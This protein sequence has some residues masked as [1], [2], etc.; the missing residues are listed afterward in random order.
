MMGT[1]TAITGIIL[2]GG[3]NRRVHSENKAFFELG[4]RSLIGRIYDVMAA[5]FSRITIVTNRPLDYIKWDAVITTD[6]F[7]K[8]SSLT[9]IHA[10][11]FCLQTPY[12]FVCACDTPFLKKALVETVLAGVEDG[13]DVVVPE[14]AKGLQPLCAVY[15]GRCLEVFERQLANEEFTIIKHFDRL[16]VKTISES[17]LRHSDPGL[18]S[19]M[20]VNTPADLETARRMAGGREQM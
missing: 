8:R 17:K 7:D 10:G 2:A 12:A 3:E 9:G 16:R 19:F 1:K 18:E 11:L 20:N 6:I 5:L 15:S 4:G 14:T 13:L